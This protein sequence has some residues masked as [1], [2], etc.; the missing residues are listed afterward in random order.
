MPIEEVIDAQKAL[1]DFVALGTKQIFLVFGQLDA[2]SVG[3]FQVSV[4][5]NHLGL[6]RNIVAGHELQANEVTLGTIP[7]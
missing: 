7:I 2:V 4:P 1:A 3:A 6:A 5:K